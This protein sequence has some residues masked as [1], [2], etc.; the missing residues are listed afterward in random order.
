[1]IVFLVKVFFWFCEELLDK[2]KDDM[3]IMLI[4]GYNKQNVWNSKQ[5]DYFFSHLGGIWGW[6][7]WRRAWRSYD[8]DM[9]LLTEF[10]KGKYFNYLLGNKLGTIRQKQMED[11]LSKNINS[12]AYQWGFARHINSGL[13]CVPSKSLV[14][15]IGVGSDATHTCKI[16]DKVQRHETAF[17]I[18]D[19]TIIVADRKYDGLFFNKEKKIRDFINKLKIIKKTVFR[20]ISRL[21]CFKVPKI[22]KEVKIDSFT[23]LSK[24]N[25]NDLYKEVIKLENKNIKGIIIEAGCALGGSAIVIATAKSNSRPLYVYDTFSMIPSPS[26]QDGIDVQK[27][28]N[29]IRSGHSSGID[30][31]RYYGYEENLFAKVMSNFQKHNVAVDNINNNIHLVRGLFKDTLYPNNDVALAHIDCDWYESVMICLERIAP[32]LISGGVLVI[33]DYDAYSGCKKA[34][35]EYFSNK[36]QYEFI[37]RS[38]LHI[39]RR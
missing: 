39:I 26:N 19:N 28:Y 21:S 34:V 2:Y 9:S 5:C 13:T 32:H 14:Q 4:S 30:G 3:R 20:Y 36:N 12:W 29:I 33:D 25:L 37:R 38:K 7:S 16:F 8:I 10:S 27:R 11:V 24:T 35:D 17:P 1:M 31:N 22:I 6:A 23:Y 15:N 18:K